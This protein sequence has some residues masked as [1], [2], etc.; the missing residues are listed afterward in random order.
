MGIAFITPELPLR[1]APLPDPQVDPLSVCQRAADN[2]VAVVRQC[3]SVQRTVTLRSV[4]FSNRSA[5]AFSMLTP[6][7]CWCFQ[8]IWGLGKRSTIGIPTLSYFG[9]LKGGVLCIRGAT[10][11]FLWL[12]LRRAQFVMH[13]SVEVRLALWVFEGEEHNIIV[14]FS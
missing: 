12:W 8:G 6:T 14:R 13:V 10:C 3:W 5:M 1:T 7:M 4:I 2:P 9:K 11:I